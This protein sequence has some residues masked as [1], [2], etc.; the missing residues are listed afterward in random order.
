MNATTVFTLL[1]YMYK[2]DNL[3]IIVIITTMTALFI[4]VIRVSII[5]LTKNTDQ[6]IM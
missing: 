1:I 5:L 6:Q 4:V 3:I 2:I